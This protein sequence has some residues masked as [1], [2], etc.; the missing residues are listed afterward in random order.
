MDIDKLTASICQHEGLRLKP[1]TDTVGKL[2]I[3]YGRDLTDVGISTAE[4]QTLLSNDLQSAIRTSQAQPWWQYVAGN[5]NW[6]NA[7]IELVF[8]MGA[9]GVAGFHGMLASFKAGDGVGAAN[10]LLNSKWAMQVGTERS[11]AIAAMIGG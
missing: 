1:Y 5:D 10:A 4:A 11:T 2:T 6:E 3:G 7:L 8:N 9:N